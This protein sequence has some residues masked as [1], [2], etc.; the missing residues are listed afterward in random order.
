MCILKRGRGQPQIK[1]K[2]ETLSNRG[3]SF[4]PTAHKWIRQSKKEIEMYSHK[5]FFQC[6]TCLKFFFPDMVFTPVKLSE[7]KDCLK[8]KCEACENA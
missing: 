7:H 1:I 2:G 5:L 8:R 3:H 4:T 6:P